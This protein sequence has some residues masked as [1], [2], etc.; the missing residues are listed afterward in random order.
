[1][2]AGSVVKLRTFIA[3]T[4]ADAVSEIRRELGPDAIVVHVKR[5]SRDGLSR[6][7]S[8]PMIEVVAC[9]PEPQSASQP[10][11]AASL[12][13]L[14]REIGELKESLRAE[15]PVQPDFPVRREPPPLPPL[16]VAQG[17]SYAAPVPPT[18]LGGWRIERVLVDSGVLPVHAHRMMQAVASAHA[19]EPPSSVEEELRIAIPIWTDLWN[20]RTHLKPP[21]K[22]AERHVFIGSPGVGKTNVLCKWMTV[23]VLLQ[24]RQAKAW[25]L[26]HAVANTAE[27]LTAHA[28]VLGV[29]VGRVWGGEAP[30]QDSRDGSLEFI[31]LPG[32]SSS[33][34]DAVKSLARRLQ[35]LGPAQIHLVLNAAYDLHNLLAQVRAFS[36]FPVTDL[37]LTHLDE[38]PRWGKL[39]SLTLG[40]NYTVRFLSHGQ[41]IPGSLEIPEPSK[42]LKRQIVGC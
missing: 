40:T 9:V 19:G 11:M 4:A 35:E 41:N 21:Q 6:L 17:E 31:D 38:E 36:R 26:D 14:R 13:E 15:S 24:G 30:V 12:V 25:R 33:D 42:I 27:A 18:G 29:P 34:A 8:K 37:I 32:A 23:E 20:E 28:E 1:M 39:W 7:W 2:T 5:V 3:P 22:G 16:E 10:G